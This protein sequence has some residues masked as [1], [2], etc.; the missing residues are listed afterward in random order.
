MEDI[1][2]TQSQA[3][4]VRMARSGLVTFGLTIPSKPL[5]QNLI[6]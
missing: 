1:R 2:L 6:A 4:A 3:S 5:G